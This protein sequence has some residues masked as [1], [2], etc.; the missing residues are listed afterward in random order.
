ML[1]YHAR[2]AASFVFFLA[3]FVRHAVPACT[4]HAYAILLILAAAPS[5]V[6]RER[7]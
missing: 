1:F 3:K 5:S 2:A 4:H 6:G 7:K